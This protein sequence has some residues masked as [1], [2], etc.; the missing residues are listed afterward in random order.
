MPCLSVTRGVL[1]VPVWGHKNDK[2]DALDGI[3]IPVQ[4]QEIGDTASLVVRA[5]FGIVARGMNESALSDS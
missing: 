4:I 1:D 3:E 5:R 2:R